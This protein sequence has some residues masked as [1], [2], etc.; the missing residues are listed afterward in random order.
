VG[1]VER[2]RHTAF[3]AG[4]TRGKRAAAGQLAHLAG[5]LAD[6]HARD[7]GLVADAIAPHD[8]DLTFPHEPG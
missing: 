3:W 1:G 4:A 2:Q 8:D 6:A 7:L 5:E